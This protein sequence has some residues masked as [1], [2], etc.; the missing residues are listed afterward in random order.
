[1]YNAQFKRH[2]IYWIL[3]SIIT[4]L[5]SVIYF[6]NVFGLAEVIAPDFN[7]E[8]GLLENLQLLLLLIIFYFC[9]KKFKNATVKWEKYGFLFL[10]FFT[11]FIFLEELDYGMHYVDYFKGKSTEAVKY[12]MYIEKKVRN[13]HNTNQLNGKFK[14]TSYIVII[15]FFVIMP[16]VPESVKERFKGTRFLSPS[17]WIITTAVSLLITNKIAFYLYKNS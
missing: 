4:V 8:F 9:I 10:A 11:V 13:I 6:L 2:L 12:E 1:M 16:L 3:P 15:L 14:T 5:F 17:K 7:R